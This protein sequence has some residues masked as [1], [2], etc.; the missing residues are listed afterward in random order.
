MENVGNSSSRKTCLQNDAG[1]GP[2]FSI[3]S[4]QTKKE[5]VLMDNIREDRINSSEDT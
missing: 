5:A 3:Y 2:K 1:Q 4:M